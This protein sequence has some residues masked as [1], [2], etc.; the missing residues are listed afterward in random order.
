M[1]E[2]CAR[3]HTNQDWGTSSWCPNC[4]FYPTLDAQSVKDES[5]KAAMP[6]EEE[7]IPEG[8]L[9]AQLPA[10]FW[11]LMGGIVAIVM[12]GFYIRVEAADAESTRGMIAL[13]ILP[14]ALTMMAIAHVIA[15]RQAMRHDPRI[16]FADALISWFTVWQPSITQLPDSRKRIWS[17]TWGM[18]AVVTSLL[19]IGGIDYNAP[20]R[21]K[22]TVKPK[23]FGNKVIQAVTG[24]AKAAGQGSNPGS[25]EKTL[26][27]LSDPSLVGE[28]AG[29]AP[30][31][32]ED[33]L[34]QLTSLPEEL[35][36]LKDQDLTDVQPLSD[37]EVD[38]TI[39]CIVYGVVTNEERLPTSFLFAGKPGNDYQHVA[40][41]YAED[42]DEAEYRRLAMKLFTKVQD[43][44][45][46]PT[47]YDAVWVDPV[48][49]C[50]LR[51]SEMNEDGTVSEA[52]FDSIVR[53]DSRR[54]AGR[55]VP[56]GNGRR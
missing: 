37:I 21:N 51:Y 38:K 43:R 22:E 14:I 50:K 9:F 23:P 41:I 54:T 36:K 18:T 56:G 33:A 55:R 16:R 13:G 34:S 40:E 8:N 3:C 15:S 1:G 7:S 24:A 45:A 10:W 48:L 39:L 25:M 52:E 47:D 17:M 12:T 53:D 27:Q 31:S 20:F 28:A 42:L 44:P 49:V 35:E 19:V 46:V 26:G 29:G 30:A 32:M 6:V 4:G 2:T 11:I 5:W